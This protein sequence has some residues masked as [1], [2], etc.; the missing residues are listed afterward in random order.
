MKKKKGWFALPL[1]LVLTIAFAA[2]CGKKTVDPPPAPESEET[3]SE[4]EAGQEAQSE[5]GTE[6]GVENDDCMDQIAGGGTGTVNFAVNFVEKQYEAEDGTA[7]FKM[8]MAYPVFEG[9]EEGVAEINRFYQEWSERKIAE[10]EAEEDSTRQSALEVY[11]ESKDAGWPGPWSEN[12]EVACVKTWNGYVSVLMDSYLY[13]GG[14]HGMPYREGHVFRLS[15][16]QEV[17]LSELTDKEQGEWDK[18]LRARF[19]ARIEQGEEAEFF[20]DALETIKVRDMKDVGYYFTETGIAF[21]LPPYEIGSYSTGY[22]EVE[23]PFEEIAS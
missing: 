4:T 8:S 5:E 22:V 1:C 17:E 19:A 13:E 23:V 6:T 18:I 20:E 7:I 2:A 21:Y 16:G 3:E 10:Y 15:D 11:R 14:A 12:Y 9:E